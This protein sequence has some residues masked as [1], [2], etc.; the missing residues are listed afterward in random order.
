MDP[1]NHSS[2]IIM[3]LDQVRKAFV[4]DELCVFDVWLCEFDVWLCVFDFWLC[5]FDVWMYV[6]LMTCV[7]I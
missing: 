3:N 5:V 6:C 7:C 4:F 1:D 2:E